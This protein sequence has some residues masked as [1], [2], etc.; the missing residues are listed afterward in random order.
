LGKTHG[1]DSIS[2]AVD[3]A[4]K[5]M[6]KKGLTLKFT[7]EELH[8]NISQ[9]KCGVRGQSH[10]FHQLEPDLAWNGKTTQL[11]VPVIHLRVFPDYVQ[12]DLIN[13]KYLH[14]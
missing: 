5:L 2:V 13:S 4:S 9:Y 10:R 12:D 1:Q 14:S 8:D 7:L 3:V 6:N 11:K